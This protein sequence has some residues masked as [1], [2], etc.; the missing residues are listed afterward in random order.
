MKIGKI[1]ESIK[2]LFE[3]FFLAGELSIKLRNDGLTKQIKKD[4]TPVTNGDIEVNNIILNSFK[5]I[6]SFLIIFKIIEA[7]SPT[8]EQNGITWFYDLYKNLLYIEY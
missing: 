3:V 7:C 6:T 8:R 2:E 4:K 5:K 1:E